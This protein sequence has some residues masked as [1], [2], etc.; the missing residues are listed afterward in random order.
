MDPISLDQLSDLTDPLFTNLEAFDGLFDFNN[1]DEFPNTKQNDL[2]AFLLSDEFNFSGDSIDQQQ[3][4]NTASTSYSNSPEQITESNLNSPLCLVFSEVEKDGMKI[5]KEL[6]LNFEEHCQSFLDEKMEVVVD[7]NTCLDLD[8]SSDDDT[9]DNGKMS[10]EKFQLTEEEKSVFIKEGYKL[11]THV[12][13]TKSE[14]KLLKLVRRKI[15][16]KK[17]A[18]SSRERKKKYVS[19]LEKRVEYCTRMNEELVRENKLLKSQNSQIMTK[20]QSMQEFVN[21]LFRKHKKASTTV[22]FVSF[23]LT[24]CI[25]PYSETV[26][27][28]EVYQ[29]KFQVIPFK[30]RL[31]L[32]CLFEFYSF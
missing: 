31:Q 3:S 11:P 32:I 18:H 30:G 1:L 19:G 29:S 14:E 27:E 16:N 13:L 12:P 15:R 28:S 5:T 2:E 24:F 25:Y 21:D 20:M 23:L 10:I 7:K 17:S 22:L 26:G 6:V 4:N 9:L 8:E